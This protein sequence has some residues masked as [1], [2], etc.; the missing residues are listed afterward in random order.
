MAGSK[1]IAIRSL[2]QKTLQIWQSHNP[3]DHESAPD[4]YRSRKSGS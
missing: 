2:L 3:D 1:V 4:R